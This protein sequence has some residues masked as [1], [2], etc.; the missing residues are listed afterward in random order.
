MEERN[1]LNNATE[2]K[3][4][5]ALAMNQYHRQTEENNEENTISFGKAFITTNRITGE[6][7]VPGLPCSN[8]VQISKQSITEVHSCTTVNQL[9]ELVVGCRNTLRDVCLPSANKYRPTAKLRLWLN[10]IMA[11]A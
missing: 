4:K 9:I 8:S 7:V 10:E 6:D 2:I 5:R 1:F 11:A 3:F